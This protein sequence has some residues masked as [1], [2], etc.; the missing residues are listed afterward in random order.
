MC[1][2]LG[3]GESTEKG[4]K[5]GVRRVRQGLRKV[6]EGERRVREIEIRLRCRKGAEGYIR[7]LNVG[8]E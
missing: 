1:E 4:Y 6:R 3:A 2:R 8:R 5:H 7:V